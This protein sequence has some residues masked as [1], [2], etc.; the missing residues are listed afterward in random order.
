MQYHITIHSYL[1]FNGLTASKRDPGN[2]ITKF[3]SRGTAKSRLNACVWIRWCFAT[4]DVVR[5]WWF[6]LTIHFITPV[7]NTAVV[8]KWSSFGC[9]VIMSGWFYLMNCNRLS[10]SQQA[11]NWIVSHNTISCYLGHQYI[12]SIA[13]SNHSLV[14]IN[15]TVFQN[16]EK[17]QFLSLI[18]VTRIMLMF[19]L[20]SDACS[21]QSYWDMHVVGTCSVGI[22]L[23]KWY[24]RLLRGNSQLCLWGRGGY[25]L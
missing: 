2:D 23:C 7:T 9:Y 5:P 21:R 15:N 1:V 16:V 6:E 3:Q 11:G 20:H 19:T 12:Q 24:M 8:H 22:T 13:W 17:K 14:L 25:C 18:S 10:L 4:Q